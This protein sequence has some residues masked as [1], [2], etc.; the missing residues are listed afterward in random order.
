MIAPAAF[1]ISLGQCLSTMSLYQ[2]GHPARERVVDT[3]FARLSDLLA[4]LQFAEFSVIGSGVVFQG[5]VLEELRGW[6][7]AS[8][9]AAAGLER[10]EIDA[11]VTRDGWATA[12]EAMWQQLNGK[13]PESSE[14]RQLVAT[15]VRFG[16]LRVMGGANSGGD[17]EASTAAISTPEPEEAVANLTLSLSDEI[18]AVSWIHEEALGGDRLPMAEVEAVVGSLAI[19]MH[20]NQKMLLPLVMLKDFDQY[21]T[22]HA[23]NVAIL[24]MGLAEAMGCSRAEVRAF[25]VAGLLHDIGK[26]TIPREILTKPG[27]LTENEREVMAT[28][29]YQGARLLLEREKGLQLAAVVAYEHH[30]CIDG[31]G[32]PHMHFG[33]G[34]HFASR[35]V[36]VCDIYDALSTNR[37]Y[38]KPW[39]S[40]QALHFI[41]QHA[42]TEVDPAISHAFSTMVRSSQIA[43]VA[44]PTAER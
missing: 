33:R 41:E 14:A 9:L 44:M 32:Y 16:S 11:D 19:A 3:S 18:A 21:T 20:A 7:W 25:G 38:R 15:A 27:R 4:D 36:H 34:C 2:A 1:M 43:P 5:R 39:S 35:L 13:G 42:G 23:C 26:V 31:G 22:T 29:P 8:R 24:S 17:A 40:E 12:L 10:F 6:D 37:P 28:H 30:I